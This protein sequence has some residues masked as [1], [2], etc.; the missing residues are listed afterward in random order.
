MGKTIEGVQAEGN[1]SDLTIPAQLYDT[2]IDAMELPS[3]I[4]GCLTG[5]G[6][7]NVGQVLEMADRDLLAIRGLGK[8]SLVAIRD[9]LTTHGFLFEVAG[10]EEGDEPGDAA[11]AEETEPE[12]VPEIKPKKEKKG[13]AKKKD[14]REKGKRGKKRDDGKKGK[15]K[16][17]GEKKTGGEPMAKEDKKGKKKGKKDDG[18]KKDKG[19]KKG[20]G[21]KK[22]KK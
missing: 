19:K 3:R 4:H 1:A 16:K 13:G 11:A 12:E 9:S 5:A 10:A 18:K 15:K 21:R 6:I 7:V 14:R 8:A 2:T 17:K 22:G 20:K